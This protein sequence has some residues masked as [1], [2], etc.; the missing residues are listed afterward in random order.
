MSLENMR[1]RFRRV[2]SSID[3]SSLPFSSRNTWHPWGEAI[4][5]VNRALQ[6]FIEFNRNVLPVIATLR[7]V[8]GW[9]L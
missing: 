4:L 6:L 9:R 7:V 1:S 2:D 8:P 5:V 3:N